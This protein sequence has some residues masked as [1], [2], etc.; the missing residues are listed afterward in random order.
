MDGAPREMLASPKLK[1]IGLRWSRFTQVGALAKERGVWDA[2]KTRSRSR[3][4][5][6]L[7]D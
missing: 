3:L 1:E 5:K 4:S 2:R 7:K 6:Q